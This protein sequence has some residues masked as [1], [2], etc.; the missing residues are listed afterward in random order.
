MKKYDLKKMRNYFLREYAI[1]LPFSLLTGLAFL[2]IPGFLFNTYQKIKNRFTTEGKERAR[3]LIFED[4]ISESQ[5]VL[6][7]EKGLTYGFFTK[8]GIRVDTKYKATSKDLKEALADPRYQHVILSGHGSKDSWGAADCLI[9]TGDIEVWMANLPKKSGYFI[10]LTCGSEEGRPLGEAVVK[11]KSKLLG[12]TVPVN[13]GDRF[14]GYFD[15]SLIGLE[16]L[17]KIEEKVTA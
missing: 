13:L 9:E 4:P 3:F 6:L 10:Q 1:T 12:F 17:V 8:K 11:D 15:G 14:H 7:G 5:S 2:Q 16:N